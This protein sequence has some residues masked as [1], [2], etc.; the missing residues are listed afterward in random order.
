M[1]APLRTLAFIG[2][3]GIGR[4]M[5]ER[6]I[7]CGF[8]LLLCDSRQAALTGFAPDQRVTRDVRDCVDADGVIVM[9]AD[10]AQVQAVLTGARGLLSATL[11]GQ[12]P[13]IAIMSSVLPTTIRTLAKACAAA[14]ARLIDAP[15]SGGALGAAAGQLSIMMGGVRQDVDG[16]RPVFAALGTQLFHC[17][18]LGMGESVKI[19]NNLV[20]LANLFLNVEAGRLAQRLGIDRDLLATVMEASSGRNLTTRDPEAQRA[21]YRLNTSDRATL[22]AMIAICRKDLRL[23]ET[24]AGTVDLAMPVYAAAKAAIDGLAQP[25]MFEDWKALGA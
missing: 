10:D 3:G 15:V 19:I 22:D 8:D 21:F 25:D 1:T 14:G 7:G 16:W 11:P 4:P 18:A 23:A 13:A 2:L 17:G 12:A 20:G 6:L 9:V 24:L 5:A